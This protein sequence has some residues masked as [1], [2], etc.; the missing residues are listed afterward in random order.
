MKVQIGIILA[1]ALAIALAS[2]DSPWPDESVT[3]QAPLAMVTN[4]ELNPPTPVVPVKDPPEVETC[5]FR[6]R[7][8]ALMRQ[9]STCWERDSYIDILMDIVCPMDGLSADI[10]GKLHTLVTCYGLEVL[11]TDGALWYRWPDAETRQHAIDVV[12]ALRSPFN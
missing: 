6:G 7:M 3:E 4:D 12:V 5:S 10:D 2:C 9:L 11:E 8:E 1:I